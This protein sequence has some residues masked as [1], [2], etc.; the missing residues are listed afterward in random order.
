[1]KE[2]EKIQELEKQVKRLRL[3]KNEL[4][5][6]IEKKNNEISEILNYSDMCVIDTTN[7]LRILN[8]FGSDE[9]VFNEAAS[10]IQRGNDL[11]TVVIRS[12]KSNKEKDA[13]GDE[14]FEKKIHK[15]VGTSKE[16]LQLKIIGNKDGEI[17][18]LIWDIVKTINGLRHY[19]RIIPTNTIVEESREH[20]KL[21][22]EKQRD[23]IKQILNSINDGVVFIDLSNKIKI[24]NTRA[25]EL[26]LTQSSKLMSRAELEGKFFHEI[27]PNEEPDLT[28][29]RL[30]INN[31]VIISQEKKVYQ[32][33]THG[34]NLVF[35]SLPW[36]DEES[37]VQG[38]IVIA[39]ENIFAIEKDDVKTQAK[40]L[41]LLKY[42]IK[43]L[44]DQNK[45]LTERVKELENNHQWFMKKSRDD[46][47]TIKYYHNTIKNLYTYLDKLPYPMCILKLPEK[48][49]EFINQAF[50]KKIKLDKKEILSKSDK[51]VFGETITEY[52]NKLPVDADNIKDFKYVQVQGKQIY[53]QNDKDEITHL[54]RVFE[55]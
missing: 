37:K 49:Y 36:Y 30:E 54:I 44:A 22:V 17:F 28:T 15:F 39:S 8:H 1:M 50:I 9:V 23:V 52:L 20:F 46:A 2:E 12:T 35:T 4:L 33:K 32:M 19:F 40:D 11:T 51:E 38:A 16:E 7:D 25:K 48:K 24:V 43:N 45:I 13:E 5:E 10:K 26:L 3:A 47:Q 27:F 41:K 18:L 6:S 55:K 34:R 29:Q 31:Q 21:Q 14:E 42:N 53:I